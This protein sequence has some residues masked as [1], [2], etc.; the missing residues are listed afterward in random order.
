MPR[1]IDNI[2]LE[3]LPSLRETLDVSER[4]DFGVGYFN[5][6]GWKSIDDLIDKWSGQPGHQCRLMV[7]MHTLPHEELRDALSITTE[8]EQLDTQTALRLKKKLAEEFRHQLTLGAPTNADEAGLR[9]LLHQL[10]DGKVVVKLF[11]RHTLI[12]LRDDDRLC[13]VHDEEQ[14]QEPQIICSLGLAETEN[15]KLKM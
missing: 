4:S 12:A 11:L 3:L 13:L 2:D 10:K 14:S 8:K 5:L 9:R 1:I 15:S 7:G 6:R